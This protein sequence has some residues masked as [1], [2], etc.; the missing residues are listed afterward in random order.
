[1]KIKQVI[2]SI[3]ACTLIAS[4]FVAC[5]GGST[6]SNSQADSK[7]STDSATAS[8]AKSSGKIVIYQNCGIVQ[9][10]GKAGSNA[11]DLAAVKK[12]VKDATGIDI[13]VIIPPAGQEATKINMLLASKE[14][15]D[16][17][18][19]DWTKYADQ[20]AIQPLTKQIKENGSSI[21][22]VWGEESM[23]QMTDSKGEVWGVPRLAPLVTYPIYVRTDWLK[24]IGKEAPTTIDELEEVLKLF[25]EKDLAGNNSTVPLMTT[26]GSTKALDEISMSLA[27]GFMGEGYTYYFDSAD[28]KVKP[29]VLSSGYKDF[30]QKMSDWYAKGYIYKEAFATDK[31]TARN[32]V[33]QGVI[34]A[35]AM[36][37][38]TITMQAPYLTQKTPEAG[39]TMCSITGPK[40]KCETVSAKSANGA[41][42]PSYSK[43]TDLVIKYLNWL[44]EDVE[45]HIVT[46][47]GIKGVNWE[48]TDEKN[49][50]IKAINQNY[51]GDCVAAQGIA[52]ESK[53]SFEDPLKKMHND[54]LHN[55][56][57]N[58]DRAVKSNVFDTIFDDTALAKAVPN[59]TDINRM[60]EEEV[61][62]FITGIRP[63]SEYDAFIKQLGSIGIDKQ[64]D[65]MTRQ[66][67]TSK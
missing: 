19:G 25:K 46:E 36:W 4:G 20:G 57:T 17:F 43:N 42:I 22:S 29:S 41:L 55:E 38:S 52:N 33:K 64:V 5:S 48:Y 65:E 14:P 2:A 12:Y 39:Y 50:V 58:L 32:M 49:H 51:I 6:S 23:S 24:K 26:K 61:V 56:I 13:E 11:T 53:Y 3:L 54:Y 66:Y 1:M 31:A 34:G 37:Y 7:V 30:V 62:K 60:V 59:L 67:S 27:A 21:T 9:S 28:K 40:G 63:M 18:W 8:G 16:L 15:I 35:S 47:N 44:Y 45:H 10:S